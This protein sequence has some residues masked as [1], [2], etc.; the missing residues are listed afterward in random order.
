[1]SEWIFT[2]G[3]L[4]V[5]PETGERLWNKYIRIVASDSEAARAEMFRRFGDEWAFQYDSEDAAGVTKYRLK[6]IQ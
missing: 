2:F 1:M 3:F 6:E 5:H 4:H